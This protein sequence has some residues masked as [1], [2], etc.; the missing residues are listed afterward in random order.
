MERE[1]KLM[2]L[3]FMREVAANDNG[4]TDIENAYMDK[5]ANDLGLSA[6]ALTVELDKEV[7]EHK[8][9]SDEQ[10]RM[11]ML[12]YVLFLANVDRQFTAD[13]RASILRI[14]FHLGF[15]ETIVNR[16]VDIVSSEDEASLDPEKLINVIRSALN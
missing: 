10:S 3:H 1:H 11:T 4:I 14:G 13:E 5:A 12:Y 8:V 6:E 7:G 2:T 15:R 16:M 9:P